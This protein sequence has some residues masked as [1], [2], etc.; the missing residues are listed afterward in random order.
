[1]MQILSPLH[2][3]K[4]LPTAAKFGIVAGGYIAA[5][6]LA[7][8][9]VYLYID[10]TAGPDRDEYGGMYA[11]GDSLLFIAVFGVVAIIPTGLAF[12][13]LQQSRKFWVACCFAAVAVASTSLAAA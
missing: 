7:F 8:C 2:R 12:V 11:F 4:T 10:L 9:V 6:L 13:F 3:L 1:M 5:A